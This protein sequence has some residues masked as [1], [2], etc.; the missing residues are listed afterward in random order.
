LLDGE[1]ARLAVGELARHRH[2][3]QGGVVPLAQRLMRYQI[4]HCELEPSP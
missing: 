3:V 1:E 4:M 2:V